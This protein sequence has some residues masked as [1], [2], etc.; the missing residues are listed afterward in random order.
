MINKE[1]AVIRYMSEYDLAEVCRLEKECFLDPWSENMFLSSKTENKQ[2]ILV[3]E[4]LGIIKGYGVIMTVLDECEILR[5]AVDSSYRKMGLGS[6]LLDGMMDFAMKDGARIFYLEVRDSNIPARV[7]YEKKG[8]KE[9]GIR[10][11]YYS[12]PTEDAVLMSYVCY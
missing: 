5:I 12:N 3:L 4:D 9:T 6:M 1:N 11:D 7:L 8:F 10:K 2:K